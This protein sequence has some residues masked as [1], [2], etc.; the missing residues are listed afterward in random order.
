MRGN[1]ITR[2]T[3]PDGRWAYT[4]YDGA[5]KT[6][7]IHALDTVGYDAHCIDL[8]ALAGNTN[9]PNLRLRL[10]NGRLSVTLGTSPVLTVDRKTF[11]V[12]EPRAAAAP[13]GDGLPWLPIGAAGFGVVLFLGAVSVL[14]RRHRLAPT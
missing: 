3:S 14:V 8:D 13:R 1:P 4:L 9:L 5:G 7:F 6:P 11:V 10:R 2:V 12:S